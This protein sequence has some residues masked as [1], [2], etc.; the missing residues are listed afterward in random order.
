M[1]GRVRVKRE[2]EEE[3]PKKL[4]KNDYKMREGN[5]EEVEEE[6]KERMR[7]RIITMRRVTRELEKNE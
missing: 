1:G 5:K 7:R 3:R 6:C 2:G 4:E